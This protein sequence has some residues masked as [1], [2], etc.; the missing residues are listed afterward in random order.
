M[1]NDDALPGIERSVWLPTSLDR[2]WEHLTEGDL[3][4]LWFGG[5]ATISPRPGGRIEL[6]AGDGPIRWGTVEEVVDHTR[7][8]WSWRTGDGDPSLVVIELDS[9]DDGV[10]LVVTETLLEYRMEYH[11]VRHELSLRWAG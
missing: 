3:L 2:V 11:P 7:I 9:E 4:E 8:Q 10:R 6:D 1:F 5:A